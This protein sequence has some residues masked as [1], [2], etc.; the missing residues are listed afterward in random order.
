MSD[1]NIE[2]IFEDES[3]LAI[4]KP[5]GLAVHGDGKEEKVTLVDWIIKN[6]AELKGVGENM[7]LENKMEILRPGIVHR[8]DKET[9]GVLVLAKTN[10]VYQELKRNFQKRKVNK[11]YSAFV[12][13]TFKRERGILYSLLGR[14]RLDFRKWTSK[15]PRG[16]VKEAHT[17]YV[18]VKECEDSTSFVKFYP[19][20]GRTH[21]IRAQARSV[22]HPIVGDRLYANKREKLLGFNRLALH[23]R[24]I[25]FKLH[26]KE[27]P[28]T[29]KASYPEDFKNAMNRCGVDCND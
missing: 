12:Y 8:L 11:E 14:S 17:D 10:E 22:Q 26:T 13:G 18:V 9:S 24:Q 19:L 25:S 20:T 29:I 6:R 5:S 23:A 2:I 3:I 27:D 7:E 16:E 28:Y 1:L 15:N 4:N 21:Q